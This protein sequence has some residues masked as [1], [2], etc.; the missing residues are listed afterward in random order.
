ML[1]GAAAK[2]HE[3]AEAKGLVLTEPVHLVKGGPSPLTWAVQ[4]VPDADGVMV[5]EL[6]RNG[7]PIRGMGPCKATDVK[8]WRFSYEANAVPPGE[9]PLI[10]EG[11]A[12]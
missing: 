8:I 4:M 12:R 9:I 3:E 5:P 1:I 6:D 10:D 7:K 11:S 2:I